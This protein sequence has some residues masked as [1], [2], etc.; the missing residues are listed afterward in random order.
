MCQALVGKVVAIDGKDAIV[1]LSIAFKKAANIAQA[2]LNDFVVVKGN[3]IIE[4]ISCGEGKE[5]LKT[6]TQRFKK[7]LIVKA[8]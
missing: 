7:K 5:L 6:Q 1:D 8:S 3:L 2:R 4:K